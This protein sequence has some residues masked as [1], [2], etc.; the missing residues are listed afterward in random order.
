M[1]NYYQV[2]GVPEAASEREIKQAHHQL[3]L[4]LHPDRTP[5]P[6]A[7]ALFLDV[8]EAYEILGDQHRRLAYDLLRQRAREL[9]QA[10][11]HGLSPYD[12]PP[13]PVR[14]AGPRQQDIWAAQLRRYVPWAR[15][16][17]WL[18]VSFCLSLFVDWAGPMREFTDEHVTAREVVFV[19]VSRSNPRIAYHITT[20]NTN[21]MLRE[22]FGIDRLRVGWP[23]TV[24]RTPIWRVVR[25]IQPHGLAAFQPYAG[26]IYSSL[27]FWPAVLLVVA[28]A[29][30]LPRRS[31]EQQLNTAVVAGLLLIITV[32]VLVQS[33]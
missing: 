14:R 26:G 33:A 29:G 30:L 7:Q 28:G 25:R 1:K 15:R 10:P 19:S 9:A 4:L 27:A 20:T 2:L 5:D 13:A 11:R 6:Q 22:E 21:F 16:L 3:A 17:N 12:P 24:W 18:I 8:Q 23:L 31:H 32:F